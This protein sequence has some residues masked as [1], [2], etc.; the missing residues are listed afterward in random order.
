MS[1]M[2]GQETSP[3]FTAGIY[4]PFDLYNWTEFETLLKLS[5]IKLVNRKRFELYEQ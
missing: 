5:C 3:T 1:T 2:S 4:V